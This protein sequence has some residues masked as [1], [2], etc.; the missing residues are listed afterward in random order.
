MVADEGQPT[1]F[2][3]RRAHRTVE[4]LADSTWG[5]LNRQLQVQLVGDAFL[6]LR[7][8]ENAT[9][10][11]LSLALSAVSGFVRV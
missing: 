9:S 10:G 5:D 6:S 11:R 8:E 3:V 2:R 7:V 1:L 4:V